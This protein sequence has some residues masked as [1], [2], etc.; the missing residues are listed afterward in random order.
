MPASRSYHGHIYWNDP[1]GKEIAIWMRP[2]LKSMDC[3]LGTV[4]DRPIGPHPCPMYQVEYTSRNQ[5]AVENFLK[6]NSRGL[7][8][9][10]HDDTGDHVIDHTIGARWIGAPLDLDIE[11]LRLH[12]GD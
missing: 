12:E 11:W 3:R 10:L 2:F 6:Q 9:L 5:S 4:H 8:I 7:S 1:D